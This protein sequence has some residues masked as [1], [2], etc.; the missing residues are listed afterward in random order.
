M[1]VSQLDVR[2]E[3]AENGAL[4]VSRVDDGFRV[5]SIH[6][7]SR[8]YQVR[9]DNGRYAC[10]CPDFA[11]HESDLAWRC[12]HILAVAPAVPAELQVTAP[13]PNGKA[14]VA[15]FPQPAPTPHQNGAAQMLIKR[16]VSPDGRIDSVSVEFS[17]PITDITQGDI[18]SKALAMLRL[19]KEIV[20]EFLKLNG[21][22]KTNGAAVSATPRPATPQPSA[23]PQP[24]ASNGQPVLARVLDIGK[25][26]G[27]WGERLCLNVE[28][29][30][31]TSRLFGS[32]KQL[33]ERIEAA[34][35]TIG[36]EALAPGARLNLACRAIT[37]PS[38]DGR[39][40]NVE[41]L[42]P[43][44]KSQGGDDDYVPF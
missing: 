13:Q 3:R 9:Q 40:L 44:G 22:P 12:K 29:N 42:L 23:Q 24:V 7:P 36:P 16:S 35:Y 37:K 15:A 39:Y 10:S 31:R 17:L 1:T 28:V 5:Y 33:A 19:Q 43:L 30:G 26:N 8:M 21:V 11:A 38:N 27:K 6:N 2:R 20:A 32:A 18:K 14:A 4:V 25:V 41:E 34:G